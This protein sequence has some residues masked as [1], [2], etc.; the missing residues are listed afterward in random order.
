M[1]HPLGGHYSSIGRVVQRS[2]EVERGGGF[3]TRNRC[4]RGV[5]CNANA[6]TVAAERINDPLRT[7]GTA[8]N[9]LTHLKNGHFPS[10]PPS[11]D[12]MDAVSHAPS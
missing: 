6:M 7:I 4:T 10:L 12:N 2:S 5:G 11:R 1:V 8:L 3:K 9:L